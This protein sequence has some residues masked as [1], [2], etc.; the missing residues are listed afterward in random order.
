MGK[1]NDRLDTSEG[2]LRVLE[3][4]YEE[5]NHPQSELRDGNYARAAKRYEGE[6]EKV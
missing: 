6:H 4:Q 3:G 5:R 1:L 2:R